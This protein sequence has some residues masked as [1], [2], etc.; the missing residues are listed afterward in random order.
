MR[1]VLITSLV[2][3]TTI[4][5]CGSDAGEKGAPARS[6]E[7][8]D[9]S[10]TVKTVPIGGNQDARSIAVGTDAVWIGTDG[11]LLEA[12]PESGA[13]KRRVK[14]PVAGSPGSMA[15]DEKA[16]TGKPVGKPFAIPFA[17][18]IDI[19][20][21]SGY[22][23]IASNLKG[24]RNLYRYDPKAGKITKRIP[25]TGN[26]AMTGGDAGLWLTSDDGLVKVAPA[27]ARVTGGPYES[28]AAGTV[29]VEDGVVWTATIKG[30]VSRRDA[31]SGDP[32]GESTVDVRLLDVLE[33]GPLGTWIADSLEDEL[34]RL[35]PE[36]GQVSQTIEGVDSQGIAV[37]EKA[38]YATADE[39]DPA[40]Y[41]VKP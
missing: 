13:I 32:L 41:V 18:P 24:Q 10:G 15:V 30:E 19:V 6:G 38:I 4:A 16:V 23:W 26:R 14:V 1:H 21:A 22:V 8:G 34:V 5:A 35:D 33:S 11:K 39:D 9:R 28:P 3:A 7:S 40:I 37:G 36:T 20:A 2:L 25:N 27:K 12:D 29:A 17:Y 31:E